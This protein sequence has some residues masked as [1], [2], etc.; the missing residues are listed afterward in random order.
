MTPA[1]LITISFCQIIIEEY[2]AKKMGKVQILTKSNCDNKSDYTLTFCDYVDEIN[3]NQ[4]LV[5]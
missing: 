1:L 2:I 4:L 5:Q 3:W